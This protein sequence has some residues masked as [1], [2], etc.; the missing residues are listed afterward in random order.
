MDREKNLENQ[1]RFV[2]AKKAQGLKRV[3]LWARPEDEEALRLAARQPHALA[4]LRR[5]VE[6]ELERELRAEVAE[7]LR[8]RTERALLAQA[9]A[10]A[11]LHPAESN[12]PPPRV[13]FE[14]IPPASER[15]R[16]KAAGW[17]YDPVAAVWHT[18][19]DPALWSATEALLG[20]LAAYGVLGLALRAPEAS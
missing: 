4:K 9:R 13:R 5:R 17:R 16:L 6:K 8:R 1:H 11:R 14:R 7:K 18:P 19:D 3:I 15:N 20:A 2:E 10:A 12:R